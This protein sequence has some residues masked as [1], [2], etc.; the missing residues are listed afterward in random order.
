MKLRQQIKLNSSLYE[1]S[2]AHHLLSGINASNV[3]MTQLSLP[4]TDAT[5][6]SQLAA[7]DLGMIEKVVQKPSVNF[8]FTLSHL[9][10][11]SIVPAFVSSQNLSVATKIYPPFVMYRTEDNDG[12][13]LSGNDRWYGHSIELFRRIAELSGLKYT[14]HHVFDNHFGSIV[15]SSGNIEQ[16]ERPHVWLFTLLAVAGT[17]L[18]ILCGSSAQ[19]LR[20]AASIGQDSARPPPR[21][22][23]TAAHNA[24]WF[25]RQAPCC[26]SGCETSPSAA[27]VRDRS[28]HLL[29]VCLH[30]VFISQLHRQPRRLPDLVSKH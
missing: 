15:N 13:P 23:W 16:L 25:L 6:F 12:N 17:A 29:R 9:Y 3:A 22:P 18:F 11:D 1:S 5:G 28:G 19:P 10:A 20:V 8:S 27:S 30:L 24:V 21:T 2:L 4:D 14:I 26:S 7:S